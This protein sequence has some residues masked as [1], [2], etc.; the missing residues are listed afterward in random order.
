MKVFSYCFNSLRSNELKV[1]QPQ[2]LDKAINNLDV[3]GH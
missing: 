3:L 2:V 1:F